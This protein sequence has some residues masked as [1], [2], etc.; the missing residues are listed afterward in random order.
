MSTPVRIA[1]VD[2]HTIFRNGLARL[3]AEDPRLEVRVVAGSGEELLEK[4]SRHKVDV[5][6][7]DISMPGMDGLEVTRIV[8][9]DYKNIRI[10]GLSQHYDLYHI[11]KMMEMG[12]SGYLLKDAELT[13]LMISP[14]VVMEGHRY[15]C[16]YTADQLFKAAVSRT[17]N[18]QQLDEMDYQLLQWV[19]E[20]K[21]E[22]AM[23]R[24]WD[25]VPKTIQ[26]KIA[27]L[28]GKLKVSSKVG[29]VKWV[30]ENGLR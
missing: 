28:M 20:E 9:R 17:H 24:E 27:D 16:R 3:L 12:A 5:L 4:L 19:Y 6:F 18:E 1:L 2:D 26:R 10:L 21:S 22:E 14:L 8:S 23:A 11:K 30:I 7:T 15:F 25:V 13:D 29:M